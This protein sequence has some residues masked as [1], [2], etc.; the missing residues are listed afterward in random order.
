M[1]DAHSGGPRARED[2][3]DLIGGVRR[4]TWMWLIVAV[5]L[6]LRLIALGHKSFWIDEIASVSIAQKPGAAFW[7]FLWHDEGNMALYYVLLRPWLYFGKAEGM[8]R[9]LSVLPGVAAIP[10]MYLLGKRLFNARTGLM[11]A[12]LFALNPCAIACSQEARAYSFLVL[13][14]VVSSYRFVRLVE[15]PSYR[16]AIAY[17]ICAGVTCYFHYFGVLIPVAHALS[18]AAMPRGGRAWKPYAVAGILF[19]LLALPVVWLIHAQDVG[20]IAW[21]P[22]P[23][24]LEVYHLG[25]Y[26]AADGGKAVGAVL[27]VLDL[28]LIGIFLAGWR[29]AW[30]QSD[31]QRQRWRYTLVASVFF[32]PIVLTLLISVVRPAFYHRF[33]IICLPSFVMMTAAG[34][35]QAGK[36]VCRVCLPIAIGILSLVSTVMLYGRVTED[37]RGAVSYLVAKTQVDD[38]VL[39][40]QSVGYFAG[41]NYRDWL[42][43]GSGQHATGVGVD[44]P[45]SDWERK[46]TGAPHVWLVLH[47]AKADEAEVRAVSRELEHQ[48]VAVETK[49]FRGVSVTEYRL[50]Q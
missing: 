49:V 44:P 23:S 3:D 16:F 26:L 45:N 27:L 8:V 5:G 9:L 47:R 33:L 4:S 35:T 41:E 2:D 37:W 50:K 25:V 34:A 1:A 28:V 39:Y 18:T 38:R 11:A 32:S 40:Y 22:R 43:G 29:R 20:H 17:G 31:N 36:S 6:G 21:V 13:A 19:A 14:V 10:M 42:P 24:L 15:E 12:A 48:Y 7:T 46:I 30:R